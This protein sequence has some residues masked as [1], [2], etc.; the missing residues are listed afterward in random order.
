ML[1]AKS[2]TY[3]GAGAS[4]PH[5]ERMVAA[6]GIADTMT[7]KTI[8]EPDSVRSAAKVAAGEAELLIT[9]VSEI[10]PAPG[11]DLVGPL[12]MQFQNYVSFAA[13]T[14]AK[15]ANPEAGRPSSHASQGRVSP[16]RLRKAWS[17]RSTDGERHAQI[18]NA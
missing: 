5:I 1:N 13:A 7:K 15:A 4:R 10:L 16:P 6:L 18:R 11:V 14:G 17:G 12:P 9:L 2:I 8:L 3:A